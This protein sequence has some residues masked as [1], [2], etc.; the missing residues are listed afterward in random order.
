[1][2]CGSLD[3]LDL[4]YPSGTHLAGDLLNVAL[5]PSDA[6]ESEGMSIYELRCLNKEN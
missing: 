5:A 2:S 1:M 6:G 4:N 3:G